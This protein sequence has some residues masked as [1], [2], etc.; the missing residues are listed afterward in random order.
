MSTFSQRIRTSSASHSK[1]VKPS[2]ESYVGKEQDQSESQLVHDVQL[3]A[4]QQAKMFDAQIHKMKVCSAR[5]ASFNGSWWP[6]PER[7]SV[8]RQSSFLVPA[9][10]PTYAI[11]TLSPEIG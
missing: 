7:T 1:A 10:N 11:Y 6:A 5:S 8:L 9:W 2:L 4:I 3:E